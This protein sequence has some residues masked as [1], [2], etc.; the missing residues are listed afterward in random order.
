MPAIRIRID[1]ERRRRFVFPVALLLVAGALAAAPGSVAWA[2]SET[3]EKPVLREFGS[4]L[5]R[6]KWDGKTQA[7]VEIDEPRK[8]P[9]SQADDVVR[10]T[11]DL[12]LS[13]VLVTDKQGRVINNLTKDD[14]AILEGGQ[15]QQVSHFSLGSDAN[16]G[17]SIVLIIDSGS[18]L[19]PYINHTVNAAKVLVNK[20]GP[21]DRMAIVT[22][23]LELLSDFTADKAQLADALEA[24]RIKCQEWN[25]P[26]NIDAVIEKTKSE[27]KVWK[28]PP[29]HGL[30]FNAL[31][32]TARELFDEEDIR[33]IV[34]FQTDG[35]QARYLQPPDL[36]DDRAV[37]SR[38]PG[39]DYEEWRKL[40]VQPFSLAD[41]I[42]AIE[43]SRATVYSV[44]P[45]FQLLGLPEA[46]QWKRA[47]IE[48]QHRLE[49]FRAQAAASKYGKGVTFQVTDEAVA[50]LLHDGLRGQS[51][52]A[53]ISK[54]SGGWIS[55]LEQ[56]E[57]ASAI[58][59]KI[60]ADINNRYVVGYY[61]TNKVHDGK[62]RKLSV[63]VRNHPE[64]IV[65]GR[66]SYVAA[67]PEP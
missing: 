40:V 17:R 32:A 37:W 14:F 10:V 42:T 41:V 34:I 6:L 21:K 22:A 39:F 46:E 29:V 58:Y 57:Q 53:Q 65:W 38:D 50:S 24:V 36:V 55:F 5:K 49:V 7:A 15:P 45:G 59:A 2:Q 56:P 54:S 28:K 12:V 23:D 4:S 60:L 43:K 18:K 26:R 62:R 13:D 31:F 66:K 33:P 47:K 27:T 61:S 35:E 64:Y 8:T 1:F 63:E 44:V 11:T 52:L 48:D 30:Q 51:A 67:G 3:K 16:I 19:L 25:T 9:S 20:L